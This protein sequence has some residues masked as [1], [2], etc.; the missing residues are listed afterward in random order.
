MN[1]N[2]I[3]RALAFGFVSGLLWGVVPGI[4]DDLFGNRADVSA[5]VVSG[6]IAGIVTST[7]LALLVG[8]LNRW[9]TALLGL[10]SLPLG[11]FVFGFTFGVVSR[12]LPITRAAIDRSEER[13]VG[14]ECRSRWSR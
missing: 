1:T 10:L 13:R 6:V 14:K 8:N 9:L 5:T 3:A 11:E 7:V 12:F 4:Q 2:T